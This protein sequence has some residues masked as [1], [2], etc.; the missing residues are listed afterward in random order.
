MWSVYTS[1]IMGLAIKV[2]ITPMLRALMLALALAAPGILA[3]PSRPQ[4]QEEIF[5]AARTAVRAGDYDKLARYDAQLQGYALEPYVESWLLHPRLEDATAEE[6]R[7]FL[8]RQQGS[9]LA[10][11]VRKQWLKVLGKNQR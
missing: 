2:T 9:L 6:V 10:E 3:A 4:S 1:S 5:L 8:A 7:D 11:Q